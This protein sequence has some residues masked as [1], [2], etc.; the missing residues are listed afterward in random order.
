MTP[1]ED[2]GTDRER[3][4][5]F[6]PALVKELN[7][8]G[9]GKPWRFRTF[10]KTNGYANLLLEGLWLRGPYLHNGSIPNLRALLFPA[11]RPTVFYTGYDVVD[12]KNVGF[13]SSGPAARREG[14]RFDTRV[15]G[16]GNEG[17]LYGT[18]LPAADRLAIIEYLKTR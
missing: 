6:T 5:S 8:I 2:I 18:K 15:R 1:I 3:L 4:D 17:H 7:M 9:K 12:L 16:N 14:W 13:V 11:E 10:R